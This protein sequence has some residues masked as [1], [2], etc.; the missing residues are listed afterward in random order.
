VLEELRRIV[1]GYQIS[2][3]IHAVTALGIPDL[4]GDGTRTSDDLAAA[5]GSD[6]DALY[7]T[8]RALA[9][10]GVLREEGGTFALTELG[11]PLRSDVEPS[12]HAWTTFMGREYHWV[13]W[14]HFVDTLRT[15]EVGFR[16]AHGM[17][18]WEYRAQHPEESAIFDRA[19]T[20][21]TRAAN[22]AILDVYDFGRFG[23]IV[24]VGGGR[25]ALLAGITERHPGV[26]GVLFD[27]PH[28][29][30]GV[31]LGDRIDI[32]AGSF[33]EEVPSG[34]DAYLLKFV[35]HD[36]ADDPAVEILRTCRRAAATGAKLVVVERDLSTTDAKLTDLVM[37][38]G[39]GGRE[40][41]LDE[42]DALFA[43]AGF[44]LL[45]TTPTATSISVLEADAV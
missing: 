28:V 6:P 14:A 7:R 24:D 43:A 9:A 3:A 4:I 18:P 44:R 8:L 10:V 31:D 5:T 25:G 23:T 38:I 42:Y 16:L 13:A 26:R 36:W 12:L 39:V 21:L 22:K 30:D 11:R 40:R 29:V 20:G 2:Q 33:F 32:V 19:M 37:L 27:Q 17:D 1:N 34:G 15:G 41:T 45:S 35:I